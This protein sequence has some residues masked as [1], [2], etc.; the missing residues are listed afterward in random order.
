MKITIFS[1]TIGTVCAFAPSAP[2]SAQSA[3]FMSEA[4]V[5]PPVVPVIAPINGWVPDESLPCYGLPG[6]ISL[7]DSLILLGLRKTWS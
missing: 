6:A 5:E 7:L 1:A 2:L 3:L 4:A